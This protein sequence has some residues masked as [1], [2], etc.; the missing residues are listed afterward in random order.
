[1]VYYFLPVLALMRRNGEES[2]GDERQHRRREGKGRN[3]R[4]SR[5]RNGCGGALRFGR[6]QPVPLHSD[7][8]T[9]TTIGTVKLNEPHINR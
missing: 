2:K 4:R 3:E 9:P 8:F 6:R 5:I 1:M 7:I